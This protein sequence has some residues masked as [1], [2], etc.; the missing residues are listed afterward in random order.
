MNWHFKGIARTSAL[1]ESTFSEGEQVVCLIYK[2]VKKGEIGRSDIRPEEEADFKLPGELL[3]RWLHTIKKPE[4]KAMAAREQLASAEDFFF[5]L[6]ELS[7]DAESSEETN[8]L[9]YL[10]ALML[11]RKRVVRA[12]GKRHSDGAQSYLHVK[13]KQMLDV[14]IVDISAD[15]MIRIQET[16]GD[17]ILP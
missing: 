9:K 4:N 13:T 2:D 12:Q 3:G 15:L 5:S 16:I 10:L 14:P 8:A 7:R 17:I 11:E 6:F 1:S